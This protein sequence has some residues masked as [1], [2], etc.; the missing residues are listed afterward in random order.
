MKPE[1]TRIVALIYLI[2]GVLAVVG[3]C[4]VA[5]TCGG[6]FPHVKAPSITDQPVTSPTVLNRILSPS[7]SDTRT[8]IQT[9]HSTDWLMTAFIVVTVLGAIAGLHG[10]KSGWLV[11]A[12]CI[13]GAGMK[14]AFSVVSVYML[15]GLIFVGVILIVVVVMTTR[16]LKTKALTAG[17]LKSAFKDVVGTVQTFKDNLKLRSE[18]TI[19]FVG[20][21]ASASSSIFASLKSVL[22]TQQ[23]ETQAL[24]KEVKQELVDEKILTTV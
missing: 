20:G 7:A 12:G 13:L 2:V 17:Q 3:V 16:T 4:I 24:V 15:S 21:V 11:S 6:C 23:P 1:N 19:P 18:T 14:A 8:I 22:N 10:I 9:V 5:F